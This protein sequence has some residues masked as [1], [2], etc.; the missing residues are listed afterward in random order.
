M[1]LI[2]CKECNGNVSDA[3]AACP[4]CG[5]PVS[6]VVALPAAVPVEV[7]KS[8]SV[9]PWIFG[10]PGGLFFLFVLI[11]LAGGFDPKPGGGYSSKAQ[12]IER[13]CDKMMANSALGDERRRTQQ[14][15]DMM[16]EQLK[17]EGGR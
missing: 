10:V 9:W 4:H 1:A 3:A 15:C 8:G 11:G 6:P 5:A 2:V 13:E 7:K 12:A 14:V 17:K 16:R